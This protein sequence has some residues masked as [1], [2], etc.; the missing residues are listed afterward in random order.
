M[1]SKKILTFSFSAI[2][3]LSLLFAGPITTGQTA[4]SQTNP[5]T[6]EVEPI[7]PPAQA[8]ERLPN[9][10]IKLGKVILRRE[11]KTLAFPAEINMQE[12]LLEVLISTPRGRLHE[13]LLKTEIKAFRLQTM[14]YLLGLHNGPRLPDDNGNQGSVVNLDIQWEEDGEKI[15]KPIEDF[16]LN[17]KKDRTMKRLGW[18][19]VG[20]SIKD[21]KF[22]ADVVGN[23]A[24][25][26]SIGDTVMDTTSKFAMDDTVYFA[27]PEV[28]KPEVGTEVKVIVTPRKSEGNK[29]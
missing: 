23:I 26:Y 25:L 15:T 21:G 11:S 4:P 17:K 29:E 5:D 3:L 19:F 13:S 12:G 20:S 14:L 7:T 10:D 6:D 9:G 8:M 28:T 16:V 22:M 24:L 1:K 18:A 2:F 27:N